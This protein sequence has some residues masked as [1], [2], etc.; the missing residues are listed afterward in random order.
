[1]TFSWSDT[2]WPVLADAAFDMTM[3]E[4]R[5]ANQPGHVTLEER[6]PQ[7]HPLRAVRRFADETLAGLS[8][9]L[10]ANAEGT[11][12]QSIEPDQLLRALLL[13]VF[14]RVRSERLLC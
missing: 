10:T 3:L 4:Q 1:M 8:P 7:M 11:G 2:G 5:R 6:V 12:R 14:Y 13:Q 9:L